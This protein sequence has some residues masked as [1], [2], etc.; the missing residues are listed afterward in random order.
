MKRF[1]V[2]V[3]VRDLKESIGFY[4]ALFGAEPTVLKENYAKWLLDEPA[5]N[6]AISTGKDS[7]GIRHL[8]LQMDND[9]DLAA[10]GQRL[11]VAGQPTLSEPGAR[12]CYAHGN[13]HWSQDPSG[14]AW[15]GFHTLGEIE[16]FGEGPEQKPA[17][18]A[19]D[20][21]PAREAGCCGQVEAI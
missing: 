4:R 5:L 8:G 19:A 3:A 7:T 15:E 2:H 9:A 10:I 12:C 11:N 20:T 13:K 1:H 6:F 14:I 21:A 17:C 18:C 16:E